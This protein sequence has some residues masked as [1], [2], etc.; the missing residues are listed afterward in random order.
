LGCARAL[1][2]DEPITLRLLCAL[3]GVSAASTWVN[4]PARG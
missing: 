4:R 2:L 3:V 1:L